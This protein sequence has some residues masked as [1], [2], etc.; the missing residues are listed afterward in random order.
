MADVDERTLI[1]PRSGDLVPIAPHVALPQHAFGQPP[2]A[3][4]IRHLH[5]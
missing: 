3:Y 2:P 1:L 5:P 4:R